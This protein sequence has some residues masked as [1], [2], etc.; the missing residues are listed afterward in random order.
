LIVFVALS[1]ASLNCGGSERSFTVDNDSDSSC[2]AAGTG[3]AAST[4]GSA[5]SGGSGGSVSADAAKITPDA[6]EPMSEASIDASMTIEDAKSEPLPPPDATG[7]MDDATVVDAAPVCGDGVKQVGE[8]CDL[9]SAKNTGAYDGCNSDC[10]YAAYC[11]DTIKNGPEACDLG[12]N[13]LGV[14]GTCNADCTLPPRCG[15]GIKNGPE[16]CDLGTAANTA[17]YG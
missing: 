2:G 15:H 10:T 17:A 12:T 11:G 13:N 4:G 8:K 16:T 7:K 3:G 5:G 14:Y 6:S 9:G 1:A